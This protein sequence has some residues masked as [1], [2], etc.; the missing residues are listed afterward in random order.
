MFP[1]SAFKYLVSMC[2]LAV[3]GSYIYLASIELTLLQ[4]YSGPNIIY[5][6]VGLEPMNVSYATFVTVHHAYH[7]HRVMVKAV[8]ASVTKSP[9]LHDNDHLD[10]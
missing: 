9:G 2:L 1:L 4:S 10:S 7:L 5:P 6:G 8:Q 3:A